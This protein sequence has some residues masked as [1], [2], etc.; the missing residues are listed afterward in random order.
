METS[1]VPDR[2]YSCREVARHLGTSEDTV[3]RL[4]SG[5]MLDGVRIGKRCLRVPASALTRYLQ[6]RQP[7]YRLAISGKATCS[8][9][10]PRLPTVEPD[11]SEIDGVKPNNCD[12]EWGVFSTVL[13][14]VCLLVQC[15][16][17]GAYGKVNDPSADEWQRAFHAPS[18][19]CHWP[20]GE[21]VELLPG[22]QDD[23]SKR[24]IRLSNRTTQ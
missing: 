19:P 18:Q 15:V 21:R 8:V 16:E 9:A 22:R 6:S 20:H 12:H 24:H 13:V 1:P 10:E 14:D 4:I 11:A 2:L 17:C 3:R 5:E 7:A 23:E